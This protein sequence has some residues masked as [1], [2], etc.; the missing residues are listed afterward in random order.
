[1]A[2]L[3]KFEQDAIAS[4]IIF[5]DLTPGKHFFKVVIHYQTI[6]FHIFQWLI[7]LVK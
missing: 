1:M 6:N 5:K 3:R 7:I 2:Q 4:E